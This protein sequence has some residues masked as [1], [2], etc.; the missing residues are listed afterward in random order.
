MNSQNSVAIYKNP[1]DVLN[2][3]FSLLEKEPPPNRS[4]LERDLSS[5]NSTWQ[6]QT[7]K[8]TRKTPTLKYKKYRPIQNMK[9]SSLKHLFQTNS[10]EF[11]W[12]FLLL[13]SDYLQ[14]SYF[15]IDWKTQ[16]FIKNNASLSYENRSRRLLWSFGYDF[17]WV[18]GEDYTILFPQYAH[19]GFFKLTYPLFQKGHWSSL[20]S[21]TQSF[22][23]EEFNKEHSITLLIKD[24]QKKITAQT[25]IQ[26]QTLKWAGLW[27]LG[28]SRKHP[29]GYL[30]N[31]F[32]AI[33]LFAQYAYDIHRTNLDNWIWQASWNNIF[34]LGWNFYLFSSLS[35]KESLYE[36]V[37]PMYLKLGWP[38]LPP[39]TNFTQSMVEDVF[40]DG[41]NILNQ[42]TFSAKGINIISVGLKKAFNTPFYTTLP[43]SLTRTIPIVRGRF[44]ILKQPRKNSISQFQARYPNLATAGNYMDFFEWTVGVEFQFLVLYRNLVNI[45]ISFSESLALQMLTRKPSLS[46][47]TPQG[48]GGINFYLQTEL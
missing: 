22:S 34:H 21:S 20:L 3:S 2:H 28:Y 46:I 8:P 42:T 13:F 25:H 32:S 24:R 27:N 17:D 35:H 19:T 14:K 5:L 41:F 26:R 44:V 45:G 12:S 6:G 29:L 48:W 43:L 38:R 31:K 36:A 1:H 11:N 16:S 37:R 39:S 18:W 33:S 9:Y 40:N 47:D 30:P 23:S 4:S 10:K 15:K 7:K